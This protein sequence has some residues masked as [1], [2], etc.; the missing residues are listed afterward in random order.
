NKKV[1][2]SGGFSIS[3]FQAIHRKLQSC[4]V[5][6]SCCWHIFPFYPVCFPGGASLLKGSGLSC[7]LAKTTTLSKGKEHA[8]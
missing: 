3:A 7:G 5:A 2:Q 8:D 6:P 1:S 4:N